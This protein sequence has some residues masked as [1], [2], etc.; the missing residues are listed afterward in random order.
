MDVD[1][2]ECI[3]ASSYGTFILYI[4][5]TTPKSPIL[6]SL[7]FSILNLQLETTWGMQLA[8][9]HQLWKHKKQDWL[10]PPGTEL[11]K[12]MTDPL[13]DEMPNYFKS[14]AETLNRKNVSWLLL[15]LLMRNA[16]H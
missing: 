10:Y 2:L 9:F 4:V 3:Y 16:M 7:H 14:S 12:Q 5:S 13:S 1:W 6:N 11:N 8:E 15:K